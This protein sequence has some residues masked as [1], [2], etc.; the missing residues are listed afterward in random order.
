MDEPRFL[1]FQPFFVCEVVEFIFHFVML[2]SDSDEASLRRYERPF[3]IAQ[4]DIPMVSVSS[5]V[6]HSSHHTRLDRKI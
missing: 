1:E 4:G 6:E 3:A 2:R 5:L